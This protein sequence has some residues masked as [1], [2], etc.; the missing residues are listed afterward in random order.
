MS[1]PARS[2]ALLWRTKEPV[3]RE[4]RSDLSVDR[5]AQAAIRIADT[6]G[7]GALTMRRVS[8]AL[9]VGTMSPYTYVPGK[10]ELLDV[11]MDTVYGEIAR[12]D[13]VEGGWRTRLELIARENWA[14]YRRHPWLTYVE[15]SR[16]VLGPNLLAKYDYELRA[17]AG[18][19]LS[20]VEMDSVLT[21]VLGHVKSAARA[22]ADVAELE[23][24]SGMT[25]SQWWQAH[26]PWLAKFA[27]SDSFPTANQVG[28]AAGEEHGAAYDPAHAFEFGL[29]RLFDGIAVLVEE[30][31][32]QAEPGA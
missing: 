26:A 1:D 14:L 31:S 4:G 8:E 24:G 32:A 3:S 28:T 9:G 17:L 13:D 6:E 25:D 21:L 16:P 22:A 15:T 5:I 12:P 11:M 30:R 29:R 27:E 10:A 19:G 7:I 2:L 20:G 23:R 18:V